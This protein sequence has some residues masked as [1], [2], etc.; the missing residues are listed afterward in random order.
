MNSVALQILAFALVALVAAARAYPFPYAGLEALGG[1]GLS[2]GGGLGGGLD[3]GHGGGH[4]EHVIDFHVDEESLDSCAG[5][6]RTTKQAGRSEEAREEAV[7]LLRRAQFEGGEAE[8]SA[9]KVPLIPIEVILS[10][11]QIEETVNSAEPEVI[12]T[13]NGN[14]TEV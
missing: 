13:E 4:G 9:N 7:N 8:S 2:L 10:T 11:P 3:G 12:Q 5:L 6:K 1:H 14:E